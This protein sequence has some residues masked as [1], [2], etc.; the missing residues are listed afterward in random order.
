M[1]LKI[2]VEH[3]DF[4]YVVKIDTDTFVDVPRFV[5]YVIA[6]GANSSTFYAGV[7]GYVLCPFPF[8]LCFLYNSFFLLLS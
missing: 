6:N 5:D 1:G 8:F 7:H 2:A 4:Q 3:F